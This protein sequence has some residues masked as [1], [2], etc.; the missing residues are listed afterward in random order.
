MT[1]KP[2]GFLEHKL[3]LKHRDISGIASDCLKKRR[4]CV[5]NSYTK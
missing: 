2:F 1:Q 4:Q 3:E 5:E